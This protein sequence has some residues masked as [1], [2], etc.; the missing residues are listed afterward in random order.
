LI[1]QEGENLFESEE[2]VRLLCKRQ[3]FDPELDEGF[4]RLIEATHK[5]CPKI[6]HLRDARCSSGKHHGQWC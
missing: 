4:R 6:A 3:R 2:E 1:E 5:L